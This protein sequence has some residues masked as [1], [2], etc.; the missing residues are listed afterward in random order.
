MNA[1]P[2]LPPA[3][4]QSRSRPEQL[5]VPLSVADPPPEDDLRCLCELRCECE[6]EDEPLP[7]WVAVTSVVPPFWL[8]CEGL[9]CRGT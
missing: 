3:C 4:S 8:E 6:P 5:S 9:A 1:S 7:W 2:G